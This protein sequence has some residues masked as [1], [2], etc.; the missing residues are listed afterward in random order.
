MQNIATDLCPYSTT[1]S[2]PYLDT[3]IYTYAST[4]HSFPYVITN[5][6]HAATDLGSGGNLCSDTAS[7][8]SSHSAPD[9]GPDF[10]Q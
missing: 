9:M 6:S 5:C 2:S 7:W 1:Y 8:S 3:Y 10:I 4:Y